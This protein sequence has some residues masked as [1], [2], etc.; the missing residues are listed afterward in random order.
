MPCGLYIHSL[1]IKIDHRPDGLF[2]T[3]VAYADKVF[4]S[5]MMADCKPIRRLFTW[6]IELIQFSDI[7]RRQMSSVPYRNYFG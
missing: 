4:E 5:A 1:G 7:G 3:Q 6:H 2:L